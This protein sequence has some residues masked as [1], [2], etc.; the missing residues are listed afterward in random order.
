MAS[1]ISRANQLC[2]ILGDNWV[3]TLSRGT[4]PPQ[5]IMVTKV[6]V[7][8]NYIEIMLKT[9]MVLVTLIFQMDSCRDFHRTRLRDVRITQNI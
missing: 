6:I 2:V 5:V 4:F 7:V 9:F 8:G 1:D 3:I